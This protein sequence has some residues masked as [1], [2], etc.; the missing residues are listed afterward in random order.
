[1]VEISNNPIQS[2]AFD[3][4]QKNVKYNIQGPHCNGYRIVK[5]LGEGGSASIKLVEKDGHQYAMKIF[6][7]DEASKL[8]F[9]ELTQNEFD[10]VTQLDL[11]EVTKYYEFKTDV[12]WYKNDGTKV[13]VSYLLMEYVDGVTLTDFFNGTFELT[14]QLL[15]ER[16]YRCVFK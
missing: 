8:K 12:I 7:P 1:M 16:Y 3:Y 5:T 10:L 14:G 6:Q 4:V 15:N 13:P 9:I 2:E 11:D